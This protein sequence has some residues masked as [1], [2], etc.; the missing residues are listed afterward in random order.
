MNSMANDPLRQAVAHHGAGRLDEA[1]RF[2][3]AVLASD[4]GHCEANHLL[5]IISFQQGDTACARDLLARSS[6]SPAATAEML[7]N[8]GVVL[9]AL[10]EID[11]AASAFARA[12]ALNPD[13]AE[14]FNNLGAILRAGGQTARAVQ[15]FHRAV[16]LQP[17]YAEA[18]ATLRAA[19]RD[20]IPAWHFSMMN[21]AARNRAFQAAIGRAAAGKNVLDIGTGAGL[22]AMMAARAQA[23]RVT[24]CEKVG[25]IADRARAI[26]AAHGL[27]G[28]TAVIGKASTDLVVGSDMPA[29][30]N[31]LV[32]ET[33]SSNLLTE[34]V[35]PTV[36]HAHEHLLTP[37]AQVIPAAASALGYLVG[38]DRLR[39]K[40]FVERSCGFN[41]ETFNDFAPPKIGLYLDREPHEA[42]SDDFELIRFDLSQK[43]F[44]MSS[45]ALAITATTSGECVGVAQWI[46]LEL[47]A[48]TSYANRPSPD[49]GSN[50]WT[51]IVY[52]FPRL[53]PVKPG[54]I[55]RLTVRHDRGQLF[56]DLVE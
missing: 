22:L 28:N 23:N 6:A 44:P 48:E 4:P 55:V 41:L 36:E 7:N 47:D 50:N 43:R 56:V 38:G 2:Y 8:F 40:L 45:R 16:E 42:L 39:D 21:D 11:E 46:K 30:A 52:R 27:S 34:G 3:R 25:L 54:D 32:T 14:A 15:A 19:Y 31:L 29:R 35:L 49:A 17:D 37:D 13:Y 9:N 10:G 26:V 20:V 53:L 24:S 18:K 12:L 33:F 5:G 51:H 1:A